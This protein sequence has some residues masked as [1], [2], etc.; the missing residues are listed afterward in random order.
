MILD[1]DNGNLI[2]KVNG[3]KCAELLNNETIKK[4]GY[5]AVTLFNKG[6]CWKIVDIL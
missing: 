4:G 3:T 6:S 5:P 1:V 2:Y